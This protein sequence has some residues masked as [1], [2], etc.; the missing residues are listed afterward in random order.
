MSKH[1]STGNPA[2]RTLAYFGMAGLALGLI[3]AHAQYVVKVGEVQVVYI[4]PLALS[5]I[6]VHACRLMESKV[7]RSLQK[8]R[9]K[10]TYGK[11]ADSRYWLNSLDAEV[12]LKSTG[13]AVGL[14]LG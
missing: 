8:K 10:P 1:I 2:S 12:V 14:F 7:N 4:I 6:M 13:M 5:F 3:I 11:G 9:L